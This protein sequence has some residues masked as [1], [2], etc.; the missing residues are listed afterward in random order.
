M[1]LGQI[2]L[3]QG[4][5]GAGAFGAA[6]RHALRHARR[7][8]PAGAFHRRHQHGIAGRK[9]RVEAAVREPGLFHDVGHADAGVTDPPDRARGRFHDA[10]VGHFFTG[11]GAGHDQALL[12][13]MVII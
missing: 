11:S 5:Q 8:I 9:M 12:N 3:D 13:M 4:A 7:A 6:P 10:V 2:A 1:V